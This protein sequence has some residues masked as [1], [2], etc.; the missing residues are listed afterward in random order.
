MVVPVNFAI[1]QNCPLTAKDFLEA[2]ENSCGQKKQGH[3]SW[4]TAVQALLVHQL[5]DGQRSARPVCRRVS[6]SLCHLVGQVRVY[7][8]VATMSRIATRTWRD[9]VLVCHGDMQRRLTVK[10]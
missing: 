10:S 5:T 3:R 8:I 4:T 9:Q 1:C 7:G 6:S 2:I